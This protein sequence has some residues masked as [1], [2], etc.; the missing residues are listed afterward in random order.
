[1]VKTSMSV[2]SRAVR[3]TLLLTSYIIYPERQRAY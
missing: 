2:D 1:M 3:P